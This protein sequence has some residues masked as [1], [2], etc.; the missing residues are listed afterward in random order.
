MSLP[1]DASTSPDSSIA[2]A[3]ITP[4]PPELVTIAI[5]PVMP[6]ILDRVSEKSNKSLIVF[7]ST[8]PDCWNAVL[9]ASE[10]PARLPVWLE[11]AFAPASVRPLFITT[12]GFVFVTAL[13]M[14]INLVPALM[15]SRYIAI[16]SVSVS[17]YRYSMKSHSSRTAL[18]PMDTIL[19]N[20]TFAA[21][22]QSITANAKAPDWLKNAILPFV[23]TDLPK[24]AFKPTCVF[25]SPTQ[26]GPTRFKSYLSLI[27]ISSDSST[28]PS[29]PASLKPAEITTT[30]EI[31]FSPH[32]SITSGTLTAGTAT[33]ARSTVSSSSK[34]EG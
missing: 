25:N 10:L 21:F 17:L 19:L 31:P 6:R 12:T 30:F 5:P 2:S 13:T 16:T 20:P 28:A 34:I 4:G 18:L 1:N 15:S 23:G 3:A 33:T 22:D 27:R 32:C 26:F 29:R 7:T 8:T 14:S 9:N 24:V 11:A